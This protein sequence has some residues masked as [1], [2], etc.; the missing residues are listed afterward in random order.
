MLDDPFW[1]SLNEFDCDSERVCRVASLSVLCFGA[2]SRKDLFSLSAS[3]RNRL[4]AQQM[5]HQTMLLV[6]AKETVQ[7]DSLDGVAT[8]PFARKLDVAVRIW[9]QKGVPELPKP[10]FPDVFAETNVPEF[11]V[12][13]CEE[14]ARNLLTRSHVLRLLQMRC[15][16]G[17]LQELPPSRAVLMAAFRAPHRKGGRDLELTVGGRALS[18]HAVR[19]SWWN[20]EVGGAKGSAAAMNARAEKVMARLMDEAVWQNLHSLP[21]DRIATF[22]IR[23]PEGYGARWTFDKAG[24]WSFRGYLEPPSLNGHET[25]WRH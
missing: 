17:S 1:K 16:A 7:E 25:G 6:G 9:A 13:S 21:P 22:E 8:R 15:T 4:A 5:Q 20:E 12:V 3:F 23:I 18:K 2:L 24:H 19:C 11:P 14:E 10:F